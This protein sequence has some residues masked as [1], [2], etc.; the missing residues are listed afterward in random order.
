MF[1][2][3]N[4]PQCGQTSYNV[5]VLSMQNFRIAQLSDEKD[6]LSALS[7]SSKCATRIPRIK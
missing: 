1:S 4:F 5:M 7:C 2:N 3:K 6:I